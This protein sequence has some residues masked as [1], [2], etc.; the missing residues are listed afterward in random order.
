MWGSL[1]LRL[2]LAY[3]L[4]LKMEAVCSSEMS[5][6][7]YQTIWRHSPQDSTLHGHR[8]ENHKSHTTESVPQISAQIFQHGQASNVIINQ[9]LN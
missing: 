5:V 7:L 3:S 1:C 8:C 9:L 6:N 2:A 4:S